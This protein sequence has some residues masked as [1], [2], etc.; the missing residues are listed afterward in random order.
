[1][2]LCNGPCDQGRRACP[3]PMAC[4]EPEPFDTSSEIWFASMIVTIATVFGAL[5]AAMVLAS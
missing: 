3:C 5:L 1:M 4:Q 2:S